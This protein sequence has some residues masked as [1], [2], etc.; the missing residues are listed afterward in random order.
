[1]YLHLRHSQARKAFK[2]L[3]GRTNQRLITTLIGLDG[4]KDGVVTKGEKFSTSWDDSNP[5]AA[6]L[7]ARGFVLGASLAWIVDSVD[8]FLRLIRR[9]P[10][11]VQD[12]RLLAGLDAAGRSVYERH[13]AV[14]AL[15][16][17]D[18][19][20]SDLVELAIT[21]RNNVV[22][23][24]AENRLDDETRARLLAAAGDIETRHSGLDIART[25][26]C[27]DGN[28]RPS[29]KDMASLVAATQTFVRSVD[30]S[31]ITRLDQRRHASD[32]LSRH[33][34]EEPERTAER[35]AKVWCGD[36]DRTSNSIRQVL[37]QYGFTESEVET[38]GVPTEEI[39]DLASMGARDVR[40]RLAGGQ[41]LLLTQVTGG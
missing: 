36:T 29:F 9:K 39:C 18:P 31:L 37:R 1:M 10:S 28:D 27:F 22:H 20:S 4:V 15:P 30:E 26:S 38:R 2:K 40:E 23:Q 6:A 8:T 35:V 33:M 32:V 21:W 24:L 14:L 19:I 3:N 34:T 25:L 13:R 17:L 41:Q 5:A 16:S 12:T 7:G 11:V